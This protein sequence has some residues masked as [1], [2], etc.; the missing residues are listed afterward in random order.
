MMSHNVD[1]QFSDCDYAWYETNV[2]V[3]ADNTGVVVYTHQEKALKSYF[4]YVQKETICMEIEY[5]GEALT[6]SQLQVIA[7]EIS[8]INKRLAVGRD[9]L[10]GSWQG[11]SARL[12]LD[13]AVKMGE[14]IQRTANNLDNVADGVYVVANTLKA[15]EEAAKQIVEAITG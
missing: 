8:R 6:E 2:D 14:K 5:S 3:G 11:E 1:Y 13:K 15:A 10:S 9:E 12:F 7:D 4:Y